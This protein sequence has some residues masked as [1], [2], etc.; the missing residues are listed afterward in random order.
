MRIF[1][2]I[3][4]AVWSLFWL[5]CGVTAGDGMGLAA[6]AVIGGLPWLWLWEYVFKG[7][8]VEGAK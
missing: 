2:G 7:A 3:V 6:F 1:L 4:L 8:S 5:A